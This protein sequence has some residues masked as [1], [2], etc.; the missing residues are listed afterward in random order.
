MP[1]NGN[2]KIVAL[3]L[4]ANRSNNQPTMA[5]ASGSRRMQRTMEGK[6]RERQRRREE[7]GKAVSCTEPVGINKNQPMMVITVSGA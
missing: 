3:A 6:V 2:D 7:R 4:P 1:N 5:A